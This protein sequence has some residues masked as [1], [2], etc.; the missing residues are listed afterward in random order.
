VTVHH[1]LH[2]G[3]IEF[4]AAQSGELALQRFVL[5]VDLGGP[6]DVLLGGDRLQFVAGFGVI[7]DH[8][9]AELLDLIT[10][11]FLGGHLAELD[12]GH[13][14][15]SRLHHE[16]VVGRGRF[17]GRRLRRSGRWVRRAAR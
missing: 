8:H 13:V 17:R 7:V 14:R 3:A 4:G 1:G 10:H 15:L 11:R 9:L 12:F 2:V 5:A 6:C 16:G